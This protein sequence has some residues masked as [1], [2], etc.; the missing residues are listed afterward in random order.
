MAAMLALSAFTSGAFATTANEADRVQQL[1]SRV[2]ELEGLVT[3]LGGESGGMWMTQARA[4]EIRSLVQDVLADADNRSSLLQGGPI[5][6]WDKGFKIGSPDGNFLL[7]LGG[8]IQVRFGW[9]HRDGSSDDDRWGFEVR[10]AKLAFSGHVVDPTWKY[11]IQGA[12]NR[13]TKSYVTSVGVDF[14]AEDVM[15]STSSITG[16]FELE[17]AY[18]EKDLGNGWY[19][20]FGQFKL[21]FMHEELVSSKRQLTVERSL[22]NATFSVVRSQAVEV[23][24]EAD[25]FRVMAAY[26]DG[27]RAANTSFL[28]YDTEYAVTGRVEVVLAGN[29][30]Q[31]DDFAS[32]RGEEF[33]LLVGGAIHY[34]GGEFGTTAVEM[35]TLSWTVDAHAEF[36]GFNLFVAIVGRHLEFNTVGMADLDQIGFVVQGGVF[37]TEDIEGFARFEW[38]DDDMLGNDELAILTIGATRYFS[39]HQLKWT[40]DIG[41]AFDEIESTWASSGA[42]WQTD[43]SGMD[44]QIVVRSQ[45]Q[46]LF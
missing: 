35:D 5:A 38:G 28:A 19:V 25:T 12:F 7:Q 23:G 8:N 45:F 39:K 41:F 20:R 10:R 16:P 21:P 29:W 2:A 18:I 33:G 34:Q 4:D 3:K 31:F 15:T 14:D 6:G 43:A 44:G 37:I 42:G 26:S 46:L 9:G 27:A 1:E 36:G 17:D 11:Q 13:D 22:I 40:T 24:Y 30:K 32:W